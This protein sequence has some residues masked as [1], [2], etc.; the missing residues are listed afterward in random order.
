VLL[1]AEETVAPA[2]T[3]KFLA[4]LTCRPQVGPL[5]SLSNL[6]TRHDTTVQN[7]PCRF[8]ASSRLDLLMC[9][10]ASRTRAGELHG[11]RHPGVKE[12]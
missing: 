9:T 2:K 10:T 3:I 6:D 1:K 5:V 8:Y 7:M 4:Q 12:L 11:R